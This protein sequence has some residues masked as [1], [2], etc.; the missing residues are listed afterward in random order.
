MSEVNKIIPANEIKFERIYS[1]GT[2]CF[3]GIE[4]ACFE[5]E[6]IVEKKTKGEKE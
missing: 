2:F 6:T 1:I 5:E 3:E 4:L